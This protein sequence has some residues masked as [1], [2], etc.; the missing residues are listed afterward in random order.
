MLFSRKVDG[1]DR[2]RMSANRFRALLQLETPDE[3][4]A[5]LRRAL[6]LIDG[7]VDVRQLA[8]DIYYWGEKTKREEEVKRR[9]AYAFN[10]PARS[11][12]K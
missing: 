8:H 12:E 4:L 11:R 5:C 6:P 3:L 2:P 7:A 9:W 10:W 1:T